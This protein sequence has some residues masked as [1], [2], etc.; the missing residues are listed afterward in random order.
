MMHVAEHSQKV[1]HQYKV[2][3]MGMGEAPQETKSMNNVF[4]TKAVAIQWTIVLS[5]RGISNFR[6]QNCTSYLSLVL[7]IDPYLYTP[8]TT[9]D[10]NPVFH[11]FHFFQHH[12]LLV[13]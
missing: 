1:V 7:R 3:E 9:I 11:H 10:S 5:D 6:I 13:S 4:L 2:D 8:I 12:H